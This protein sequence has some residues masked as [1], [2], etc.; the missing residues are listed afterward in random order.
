MPPW[1]NKMRRWHTYFQVWWLNASNAL[2]VTFVNRGSNLL[3]MMGKIIRLTMSLLFLFLIKQQIS[4]FAGY[5]THQ[6]IIF[7]LTYQFIDVL[8]QIFYRGAYVFRDKIVSGEFDFTLIRPISPLFQVLTGK[9]DVNDAIFIIPTTVAS[10]WIALSLNLQFSWTN[11]GWYLVLL[12]N[13]FLIA[14]ALHIMVLVMGILLKE[15]DG[16]MWTYR[17][18][19]QLARFPVNIYLEPLRWALF[20]VVPV[21]MMITI[22]A[23]VLLGLRPT[24]SLAIVGLIGPLFLIF[25]LRLWQWS[26]KKYASASS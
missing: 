2:Q 21:G 17:D 1:D 14:T 26:L 23:E 3:F 5:T 15:V 22:P 4:H 7:F 10:V 11:F 20:F 12:I 24:Y 16:F 8:A 25:S 6:V 9:P 18:L 19:M 13:S